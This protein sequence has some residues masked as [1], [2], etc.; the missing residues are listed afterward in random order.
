MDILVAEDEPVTRGL[1]TRILEGEGH[2]VTAVADGQSALD[3]AIATDYDVVVLDLMMPALHGIAVARLIRK[4]R[5][6]PRPWMVAL[7]AEGELADMQEC[8][9]AGMNDYLRKPARPPL[10]REALQRA[11][12]GLRDGDGGV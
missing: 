10:M 3:A 4:A 7:T 2:R 12:E 9:E 1:V 6:G 5:P 11:A 8:L